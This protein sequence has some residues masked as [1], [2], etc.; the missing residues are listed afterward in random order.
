MQSKP[1]IST[2]DILKNHGKTTFDIALY[3]QYQILG[4][5]LELK[6]TPYEYIALFNTTHPSP[7]LISFKTNSF[8]ICLLC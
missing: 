4:I 7:I 5:K 8:H 1:Y 6:T 2:H 3:L